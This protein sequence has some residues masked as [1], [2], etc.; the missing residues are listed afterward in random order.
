[1]L[2]FIINAIPCF[3]FTWLLLQL[4]YGWTIFM[5]VLYI[6]LTSIQFPFF[7]RNIASAAEALYNYFTL[8]TIWIADDFDNRFFLA[9][10]EVPIISFL[11]NVWQKITRHNSLCLIWS[12]LLTWA[13][14]YDE[15]FVS[16]L[17]WVS[18][19][20]LQTCLLVKNTIANDPFNVGFLF[21]LGCRIKK[22]CRN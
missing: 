7:I 20:H 6:I 11:K 18:S 17:G 15:K 9:T 5:K 8:T 13:E 3:F 21:W 12:F 22:A 19:C 4:I 14:G 2:S 1:M 10:N 16:I